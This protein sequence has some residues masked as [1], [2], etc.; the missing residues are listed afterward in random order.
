MGETAHRI[1]R[2]FADPGGPLTRYV[3]QRN[4]DGQFILAHDVGGGSNKKE[5][6]VPVNMED[7]AVRLLSTGAYKIRL[8]PEGGRTIKNAL[9]VY[10]HVSVTELNHFQADEAKQRVR[11]GEP[12]KSDIRL[13]A[14]D[15]DTDYKPT[16]KDSR[17][18]AFRQ[19]KLRRGQQEFRNALLERYGAICVI[20]GCRILD[21]I[22]A[23]HIRP[24]RGA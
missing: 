19:I 21:V 9:I 2:W 22:E 16:D 13:P 4:A 7:E 5:N 18:T 11:A 8:M 14:V 3:P 10:K 17:E 1:Y 6:E 12:P 20:S 24:Y 15:E 23:A